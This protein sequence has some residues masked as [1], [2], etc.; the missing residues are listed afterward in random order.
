[1]ATILLVDDIPPVRTLFRRLLEGQGF[2]VLE[3]EDAFRA[4]ELYSAHSVDL[5]ITDLDM[6]GMSGEELVRRLSPPRFLVVSAD[7]TRLPFDWPRLVKPVAVREFL[8]AVRG[9]LG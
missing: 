6:P 7:P 3:A 9:C 1:M 4:V 8:E 5:L 2:E